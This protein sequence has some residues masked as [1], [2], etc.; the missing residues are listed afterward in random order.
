LVSNYWTNDNSY[1]KFKKIKNPKNLKK[2]GCIVNDRNVVLT[3]P[4]P[5]KVLENAGI[6]SKFVSRNKLDNILKSIV[7]GK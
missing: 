6:V 7:V 4:Y 5:G 1:L 3:M 2:G